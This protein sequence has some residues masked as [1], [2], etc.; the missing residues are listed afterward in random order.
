MTARERRSPRSVWSTTR[1]SSPVALPRDALRGR[2]EVDRN[3][4]LLERLPPV[5]L[6][7]ILGEDP[8]M[9]GHVEDPLL[10]V[11][12]GQLA[13]DLRERLDDAGARLAHARPERRREPHRTGPDDG[14]VA[15]LVDVVQ[16]GGVVA[17][18][19][20]RRA[21]GRRRARV[22]AGCGQNSPDAR[23]APLRGAPARARGGVCGARPAR[24]PGARTG[25]GFRGL[26]AAARAARVPAGPGARG[27]RR[28]GRRGSERRLRLDARRARGAAAPGTRA[29]QRGAGRLRA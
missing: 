16:G 19:G 20:G 24:A 21:G 1:R 25:A 17:H 15:D 23:S 5:G 6:H 11:E 12:R 9:P 14:D 2:L 8:G 4:E 26:R 3:V 29:Q 22:R 10:R 27:G 18:R 28:A 13:A 7:E